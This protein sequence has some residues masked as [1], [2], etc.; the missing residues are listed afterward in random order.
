MTK[1]KFF[2]TLLC[3]KDKD[4]KNFFEGGGGLNLIKKIIKAS[5]LIFYR[6]LLPDNGK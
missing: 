4:L 3:T 1:M 6:M 5:F 2:Y